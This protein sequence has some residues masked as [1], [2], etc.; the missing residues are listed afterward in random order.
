MYDNFVKS[1]AFV[2]FC[3]GLS[4][5]KIADILRE[6]PGC[7]KITHGTV[8]KW[9]ETPDPGG[10]TWEERKREYLAIV[11]TT[12]RES[13]VRQH[14]N[15]LEETEGIIE[16]VIEEIKKGKL[17]FKTKDAAIYALRSLVDWRERVTDKEKRVKIEDQVQLFIE[18]MHEIPEV[19]DVLSKHRDEIYRRFQKKALEMA[20]SRRHGN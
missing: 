13:V 3:Q 14:K 10:R 19:S 15:I 12:E 1:E 5:R 16:D 9:A 4:L 2:F 20:R 18:A 17:S 11:E 7:E 6:K 8:K